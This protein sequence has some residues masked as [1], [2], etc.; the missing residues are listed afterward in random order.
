MKNLILIIIV[1]CAFTFQ[2]ANAQISIGKPNLGF[3]KACAGESFNTYNVTFSFSPANNLNNSNQF[4]V[5]LFDDSNTI[6]VF[7]SVAGSVTTSP[8]TL[9]FSVPTDIAGENFKIRIK[10]TAPAAMSSNSDAFAAYYKQQDTP[11]SINNLI[12]TAVFCSG[13]SYLLTIDNPG[14]PLN[15]SP[16]QYPS[17]TFNWFRETGPTTSVFVAE[18]NSLEVSTP[19]TY[20]VETNYGSCTSNSFSN[21][22]IVSEASSDEV[23]ASVNSSLGN[24]FCHENGPTTLSTINGDSYQWFK[25]GEIINNATNQSYE[26]NEEGDYSVLIG[27]GVC[28]ATANIKLENTGFNSSIDI[29]TNE[30]YKLEEGESLLVT[31]TTDALAPT[32]QWFRNNEPIAGATLDNYE[33]IESGNYSVSINQ[34]A[35]CASTKE[36]IF[37]ISEQF[38]DVTNIPNLI[39]P[40]GDTENDTWVIPQEYT[41]GTNTQVLIINSQGTIVLN[42]TEYQNNWPLDASFKDVNPVFFYIITPQN[43]PARK[44]TITVIK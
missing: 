30:T 16:L 10:S 36:Y 7:T 29:D 44:G 28:S 35:V 20:F 13:E 4:I 3:T 5:E 26:T 15:D 1:I 32:F 21:R 6:E 23:E 40:N 37:D 31:V 39:S 24:P 11:F 2:K 17:L 43:Q 42:T 18:G 27:L 41:S 12:E 9:T 22:V 14:G 33:V 8:A 19:G 34:T 38:P 25:D